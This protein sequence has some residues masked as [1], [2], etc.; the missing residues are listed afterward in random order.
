[1]S[2]TAAVGLAVAFLVLVVLVVAR[3]SYA[4]PVDAIRAEFGSGRLGGCMAAIAWRESRNDPRA[5]N[6]TDRH[7]DGSRGSFGLFQ[8]GALW[9]RPGEP[10]AAFAQRMYDPAANARL[11]H[12]IY[13]RYG[14]QPW[15]GTCG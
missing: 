1:V 15:G 3:F 12:H 13:N 5:A 9:R 10:V 6:W 11:A 14:L 8:L 7:A 2:R 4:G